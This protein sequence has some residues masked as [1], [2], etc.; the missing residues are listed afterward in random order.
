MRLL[1]R[2]RQRHW[3][4]VKNFPTIRCIKTNPEK[5]QYIR[6]MSP[7][8]TGTVYTSTMR[9]HFIFIVV[10]A[11][12]RWAEIKVCRNPPTSTTTIE[13]LC[14]IFAIHGSPYVMVSQKFKA[15]GHPATNGLAER[16]VQTLK[17]SWK[18]HFQCVPKCGKCFF[19]TRTSPLSNNKSSAKIY[20]QRNIRIQLDAIGSMKHVQNND[21]AVKS[22][23]L[24]VGERVQTRCYIKNQ[25]VWK[26]GTII[27]KFEKLHYQVKLDDGYARFKR[28]VNQLRN[29]EIPKRTVSFAP[30]TKSKDDNDP[31]RQQVTVRPPW[32]GLPNLEANPQQPDGWNNQDAPAQPVQEDVQKA[33]AQPKEVVQ[34]RRSTRQRKPPSYLH[35]FVTGRS[36]S[37][38]Y[39][40]C[41]LMSS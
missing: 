41:I 6:G 4:T 17:L 3:A 30:S 24:S 21:H 28:H 37:V 35:D 22:T 10:G 32:I 8:E 39:Y 7:S 25:A 1:E 31:T 9:D 34:L 40:I 14:D 26:L 5:V 38:Y 12:S 36:W 23:Q 33:P 16:N 19:E 15:P 29:T 11:K 13:M 2:N 18:N 27:Q 20:L